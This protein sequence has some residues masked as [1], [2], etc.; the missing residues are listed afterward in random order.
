MLSH[1]SQSDHGNSQPYVTLKERERE[2]VCVCVCERETVCVCVCVRE[3]ERER[4][5]ERDFL[6]SVFI[7]VL[8]VCRE[9]DGA[10][11]EG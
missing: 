11:S 9:R 6:K 10:R 7:V 3:R 1:P 5:N 8:S 4:E 2:S